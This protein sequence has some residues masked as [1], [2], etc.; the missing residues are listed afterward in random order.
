[1]SFVIPL[2]NESSLFDG[3]YLRFGG[4]PIGATFA[5]KRDGGNFVRFGLFA[6]AGYELEITRSLT[7]RVIDARVSF[8]MGTKRAMDRVGN[9]LDLGLQLGTGLVL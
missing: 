9:W 1:M 2:A 4:S 5:R 8:D 3:A 7:W 6:G